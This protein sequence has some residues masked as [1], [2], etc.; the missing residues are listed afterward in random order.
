MFHGLPFVRRAGHWNGDFDVEPPQR[1]AF[2]ADA[3]RRE[4]VERIAL[5]LSVDADRSGYRQVQ[6]ICFTDCACFVT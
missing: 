4:D 3:A 6:T 2:L 5:R 1:Q